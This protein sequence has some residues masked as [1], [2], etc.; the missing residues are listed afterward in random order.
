MTNKKQ[1]KNLLTKIK[2]QNNKNDNLLNKDSK[3]RKQNLL[4][5]NNHKVQLNQIRNI[6][7][8]FNKIYNLQKRQKL[9]NKE[10]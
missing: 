5:R 1:M 4:M 6:R 3:K 8:L 10:I 2:N 7:N 9:F